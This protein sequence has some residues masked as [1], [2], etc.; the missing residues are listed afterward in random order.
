MIPGVRGEASLNRRR[1]PPLALT[2]LGRTLWPKIAD[3]KQQKLWGNLQEQPGILKLM[4]TTDEAIQND[5]NWAVTLL[6]CREDPTEVG[7]LP[8]HCAARGRSFAFQ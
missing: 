1:I 8:P 7:R 5:P 2:Y 3:I 6:R 4:R